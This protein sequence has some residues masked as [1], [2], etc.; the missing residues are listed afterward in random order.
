MPYDV[1]NTFADGT[2]H[3]SDPVTGE[4]LSADD[5]L[6]AQL[7]ASGN[8]REKAPLPVSAQAPSLGLGTMVGGGVDALG[9]GLK[10]LARGTNNAIYGAPSSG[11]PQPTAAQQPGR[12]PGRD[13]QPIRS[14]PQPAAV[15]P[16]DGIQ[17]VVSPGTPGGYHP[18]SRSAGGIMP[19][20]REAITQSASEL[21]DA[22]VNNAIERARLQGDELAAQR[23]T[24]R[25][26]AARNRIQA[27]ALQAPIARAEANIAA[28][29]QGIDQRRE[30]IRSMRVD[31]NRVWSEGGGHG[32]AAG[33]ILAA[34]AAGFG[35]F[36]AT[37]G[38]G[39]NMAAQMIESMID[40]DIASQRDRIASAKDSL[41]EHQDHFDRTVSKSADAKRIEQQMYRREQAIAELQVSAADKGLSYLVPNLNDAVNALS[42]KQL[43]Q[44][45]ELAKLNQQSET[46][47]Y[48]M[49]TGPSVSYRQDP[50]REAQLKAAATRRGIEGDD[51]RTDPTVVRG[52][53]GEVV[54]RTNKEAAKDLNA[55]AAAAADFVS[56]LDKLKELM[57]KGSS[58]SAQ[59]RAEYKSL[60]R[61]AQIDYKNVAGLGVLSEGD[62]PFLFDQ[63]PPELGVTTNTASAIRALETTKKNALSKVNSMHRQAGIQT[64]KLQNA[65]RSE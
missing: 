51:P 13:L 62:M 4:E 57:S 37:R 29:Q 36:A 63:I 33:A 20:D 52:I 59:D 30:A 5:D 65:L 38:G 31:P 16:L 54:G 28:T 15:D 12:A 6:L 9:N 19:Q 1:V 17:R 48:A 58:L 2:H 35:Q 21:Y 23:E 32:G 24:S 18:T 41:L 22:Q 3:L 49:P 61:S 25:E 42:E 55:S 27:D 26:A 46:E 60:S 43:E 39:Q 64:P 8:I 45:T 53:N 7:Q 14:I 47:A 44:A 34:V 10:S 50:L 56:K 40:Q 11:G